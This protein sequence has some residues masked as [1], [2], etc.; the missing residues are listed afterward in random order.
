M[1]M[2]GTTWTPTPLAQLPTNEFLFELL[3]DNSAGL[4]SAQDLRDVLDAVLSRVFTGNPF[5]PNTNYV[6]GQTAMVSTGTAPNLSF[7]LYVAKGPIPASAIPP[8]QPGASNLWAPLAGGGSV[9]TGAADTRPPANTVRPGDLYLSVTPAILP[10]GAL[11]T[12]P[13]LAVS[14]GTGWHDVGDVEIGTLA[15]RP[16]AGRQAGQRYF[17]T[18]V[19]AGQLQIWDGTA[20][21]PASTTDS[22]FGGMIVATPV[23]SGQFSPLTLPPLDPN[24]PGRFFISAYHFQ[25]PPGFP[26]APLIGENVSPGDWLVDTGTT[27]AHVPVSPTLATYT[28]SDKTSVTPLNYMPPLSPIAGDLFINSKDNASWVFAP[29]PAN[30][31]KLAWLQ[32][33]GEPTPPAPKYDTSAEYTEGDL[34]WYQGILYRANAELGAGGAQKLGG[35]MVN[36]PYDGRD[37]TQQGEIVLDTRAGGAGTS[38]H[39]SINGYDAP[40]TDFLAEINSLA[41]GDTLIVGGLQFEITGA[42]PGAGFARYDVT[43]K[44]GVVPNPETTYS[45]D[46]SVVSAAGTTPDVSAFWDVVSSPALAPFDPTKDYRTGELALVPGATG[47]S[48]YTIWR[49]QTDIAASVELPGTATA[50]TDWQSVSSGLDVEVGIGPPPDT[51][52]NHRF[53]IDEAA[54]PS[55]R[56]MAGLPLPS[57]ENV[58]ATDDHNVIQWQPFPK[59]LPNPYVANRVLGV[60]LSG[61]LQWVDAIQTAVMAGIVTVANDDATLHQYSWPALVTNA[62]VWDT[63]SNGNY[64][65][66]E[67]PPADGKVPAGLGTASGSPVKA[68]D[69]LIAIDTDGDNKADDWH[70]IEQ[71]VADPLPMFAGHSVGE[72]LAITDVS[73]GKADWSPVKLIADYVAGDTYGTG[74]IAVHNQFF[75][76]A[77]QVTKDEPSDTSPQ[78]ERIELLKGTPDGVGIG[79]IDVFTTLT[80]PKTHLL[81]DGSTFDKLVYPDLFAFLGSDKTPDLRDKFVRGWS[82]ARAP[83]NVQGQATA[84]PT[85]PFTADSAGNHQHASAGGH[86]HIEGLPGFKPYGSKYGFADNTGSTGLGGSGSDQRAYP[87]TSTE[88]DHQHAAAGAHTHTISGGDAET[89][90]AN[91]AV[92]YAIQALPVTALT[93]VKPAPPVKGWA[94]GDWPKDSV[95][96]HDGQLWVALSDQPTGS[97]APAAPGWESLAET[98]MIPD[99]AN[100]EWPKDA[101]VVSNGMTWRASKIIPLGSPAPAEPDWVPLAG[102]VTKI[103]DWSAKAWPKDAVVV[104]PSGKL[105]RAAGDVAAS[106]PAPQAPNW[107]P[108]ASAGWEVIEV[109]EDQSDGTKKFTADY[110]KYSE[111]TLELHCRNAVFTKSANGLTYTGVQT[112]HK[113]GGAAYSGDM[114]AGTERQVVPDNWMFRGTWQFT[115]NDVGLDFHIHTDTSENIVVK[116]GGPTA[117]S[118]EFQ[119]RWVG[120]GTGAILGLRR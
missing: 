111:Y 15:A 39:I 4:I 96:F 74:S 102:G 83:M 44:A 89:R 113:V 106:A 72:V 47:D 26:Y 34:A 61:K 62:G 35:W 79:R 46:V 28:S 59:E 16:V 17:A 25:I 65:V 116:S 78:W 55:T 13:T 71:K 50:V 53:Y 81:C 91:T 88:G 24:H 11:P 94:D 37:A 8:G 120:A 108:L 60:D 1:T 84:K 90:P 58:L 92:V 101:V 95:V 33:S 103:P 107:K 14:D 75:W 7:S 31:G 49:A 80:I 29:D 12:W 27:W 52:R 97:G 19:G 23:T 54:T 43:L 98:T 57:A 56:A 93:L 38:D 22:T 42:T 40:G 36:A 112:S 73:A 86:K 109:W 48:P 105:W 69:W 21:L 68:G 5:D 119:V 117:L 114:S 77:L 76:R 67:A 87:Y 82:A 115:K 18:N 32:I 51:L 85:T 104:G 99:W 41:P 70:L 30:P 45:T 66:V 6:A 110:T 63:F 118:G 100:A 64:L 10:T 3:A 9:T 20:W 2:A